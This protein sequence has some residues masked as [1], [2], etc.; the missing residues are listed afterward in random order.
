M[1]TCKVSRLLEVSVVVVLLANSFRATSASMDEVKAA[2]AILTLS[3]ERN[4]KE[5][6]SS[7][8]GKLIKVYDLT[9][10]SE[11]VDGVGCGVC[12][13]SLPLC[14]AR[15][16]LASTNDKRRPPPPPPPPPPPHPPHI[17]AL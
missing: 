2:S 7:D 14:L 6:R 12:L 4:M 5:P 17:V 9:N 1:P 13:F 15:F 3:H 10:Q 11:I 16:A 8:P